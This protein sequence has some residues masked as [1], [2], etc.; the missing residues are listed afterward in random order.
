ML[1][2]DDIDFTPDG[3]TLLDGCAIL[4]GLSNARLTFTE[5]VYLLYA[6]VRGYSDQYVTKFLLTYENSSGERV[7]YM[8][9]DGFSVS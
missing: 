9:V 7:T 3:Y 1:T 6:E 8:N 4:S 5:P 2:P